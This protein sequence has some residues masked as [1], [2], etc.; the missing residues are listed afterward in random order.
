VAADGSVTVRL[1]APAQDGQAN[2]AL[3]AYLAQVFKVSKS[4]VQL[5]TGHSAR[6]KKVT[7]STLE[8]ADLAATLA[9]HQTPE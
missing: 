4:S 1:K 6:F 3:I 2:T 7:L 5:V 8:P 9:Q